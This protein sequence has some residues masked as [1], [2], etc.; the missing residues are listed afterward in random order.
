MKLENTLY[1]SKCQEVFNR[2]DGYKCPVCDNPGTYLLLSLNVTITDSSAWPERTV[3]KFLRAVVNGE[4]ITGEDIQDAFPPDPDN[5][6]W[7]IVLKNG[8]L[9]QATGNVL[10]VLSELKET[11]NGDI[12]LQRLLHSQIT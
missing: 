8:Q 5:I 6:A 11:K 4:T 3:P 2:I 1:C 12:Q 10:L 9:Y 7:R